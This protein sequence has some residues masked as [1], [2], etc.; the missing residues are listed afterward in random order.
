M[1]KVFLFLSVF[2]LSCCLQ[3]GIYLKGVKANGLYKPG[4][5][6][7]APTDYLH[8]VSGMQL[9]PGNLRRITLPG[10]PPH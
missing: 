6:F 5:L 9:Q 8:R 7:S 10:W 4:L 1:K 2:I 3:A